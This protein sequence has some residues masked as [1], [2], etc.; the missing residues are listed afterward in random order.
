MA[1]TTGPIVHT[2]G[3]GAGRA[4]LGDIAVSAHTAPKTTK[5]AA[6]ATVRFAGVFVEYSPGAKTP[7]LTPEG[8]VR[9]S[10]STMASAVEAKAILQAWSAPSFVGA[11]DLAK[12]ADAAAAGDPSTARGDPGQRTQAA[13]APAGRATPS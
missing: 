6:R 8:A 4:I 7:D 3:N 1:E 10:G 9:V 12:M 11:P 5:S 2:I 13:A